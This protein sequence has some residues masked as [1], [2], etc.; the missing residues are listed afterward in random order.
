MCS[1]EAE[2]LG[3]EETQGLGGRPELALLGYPSSLA[4]TSMYFTT[5]ITM[6]E[7]TGSFLQSGCL[8]LWELSYWVH[9]PLSQALS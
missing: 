7:E 1:K 6:G 3:G 5:T 9:W 8:R 4:H 2:A